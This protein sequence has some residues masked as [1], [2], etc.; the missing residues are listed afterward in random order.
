MVTS[1]TKLLTSQ[2]SQIDFR[3]T[4]L[5]SSPDSTLLL[6]NRGCDT[7]VISAAQ[8]TGGGFDLPGIS[9][10]IVIPPGESDM[11]HILTVLDTI[12]KKSSSQATLALAS[13]SD[14]P[15]A[16]ITLSRS[17][18]YPINYP[19]RLQAVNDG[20]KSGETFILRVLADSLPKDLVRFDA[21]LSVE[22][23]DMLFL[24]SS[25]IKNNISLHGDS[26][27]VLGNPIIAPNSIIAE[28]SYRV[29][30]SKDSTTDLMLSDIHFN[31]L[32]NEYAKCMALSASQSHTQFH[33]GYECGD[34]TLMKQM[35]GD[36]TAKIFA[37]RPNPSRGKIDLDLKTLAT[38][39]I[40]V[41]ISDAKGTTVLHELRSHPKGRSIMTVDIS[42]LSSGA[43]YIKLDA[44]ASHLST[45]FIKEK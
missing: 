25:Q 2:L 29:Y 30:L 37:L 1:G 43:Y 12:G 27:L 33:Y 18:I 45:T 44:G 7:L 40:D 17:Y 34:I 32:D 42:N 41:N 15:L 22:H 21:K 6:Q 10:P 11:L 13:T 26:L 19:I 38:E 5:C 24:L 23:P 3:T 31:P 35:N 39:D 4:R 36:I 14:E 28:C 9:F 20:L 8:F 16:P